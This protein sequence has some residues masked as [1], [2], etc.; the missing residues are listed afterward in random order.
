MILI[1]Q[2]GTTAQEDCD[3]KA[4]IA[5][6]S[7]D[8]AIEMRDIAFQ[9]HC[10]GWVVQIKVRKGATGFSYL[11]L[12][13]FYLHHRAIAPVGATAQRYSQRLILKVCRHGTQS[14]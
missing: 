1:P 14:F 3:T 7:R 10:Y 2:V 13:C 8:R 12:Y 5:I 9:N 11:C 6:S 4:A